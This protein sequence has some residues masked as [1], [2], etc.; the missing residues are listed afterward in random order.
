MAYSLLVTE[1]K[2]PIKDIFQFC[3]T[4]DFYDRGEKIENDN[5]FSGNSKLTTV[6]HIL[7][8]KCLYLSVDQV[9]G[10]RY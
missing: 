9:N 8:S 6:F 5:Q 1:I 3:P 7:S 10:T 4:I 2:I